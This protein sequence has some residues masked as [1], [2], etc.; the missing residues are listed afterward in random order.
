MINTK[1]LIK[2]T[3]PS[4]LKIVHNENYEVKH[5][6]SDN[7]AWCGQ[8]KDQTTNKTVSGSNISYKVKP[9]NNMVFAE[10]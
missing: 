3:E 5:T 10:H 4:I 9:T 6:M 1:F 2:Y 7:V 8:I